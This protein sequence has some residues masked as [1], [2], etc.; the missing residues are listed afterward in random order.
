M[1]RQAES[2]GEAGGVEGGGDNRAQRHLDACSRSEDDAGL[3][4]DDAIRY[5]L[6]GP[7]RPSPKKPKTLQDIHIF[8]TKQKK[9]KQVK[10]VKDN[11]VLLTTFNFVLNS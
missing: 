6:S 10:E 2:H 3:E 11:W 1:N 9:T 8:K 7:G 4:G 5:G